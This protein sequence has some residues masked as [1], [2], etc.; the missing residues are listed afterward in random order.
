MFSPTLKLKIFASLCGILFAVG[1]TQL[2]L[3]RFEAGNVYPLYSSL[4]SDPMGTRV[5]FHGYDRLSS[6]T[7]ERNYR[8]WQHIKLNEKTTMMII[9]VSDTRLAEEDSAF[10]K[11][12]E[13]LA[14]SGGRLVLTLTGISKSRFAQDNDL[15]DSGG[16]KEDD[17]AD[18][19]D[20]IEE[21]VEQDAEDDDSSTCDEK[22]YAD[23][24]DALGVRINTI[25]GEPTDD[26][27]ALYADDPDILSL[28]IPWRS[29][30]YFELRDNTWETIYT[31]QD[32]PVVVQRPW[33]KGTVVMAADSYLISNE[34]MRNNRRPGFLTWL[35]V[36]GNDILF[37][38][39]HKGLVKQP[40]VAGLARQYR[41][42]GAFAALLAV[43]ILFVWRQSVIFVPKVQL[44][45]GASIE[46]P[47]VGR[48]TG[49]G[50]VHLARQ[51][52]GTQELLS[53]C[54]ETW[55]AQ[56]S[57]HVPP[58]LMTEI[59]NLVQQSTADSRK[60]VQ[61]QTYKQICQLLKQGKHP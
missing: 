23:G 59:K 18:N 1:L 49:Q 19:A 28:N 54:F 5:L 57:L 60:A 15:W 61:V 43:A 41:L 17:I 42:H 10:A 25:N 11:L 29:Q 45:Q 24:L 14:Q 31:W 40:G 39:Y 37:D 47:T 9:G 50:M 51:H 4:R 6:D 27:A 34:A 48:D 22:G 55:K 36:P 56:A 16:K 2:F 3:L 53:V 58:S 8:P 44:Q 21:F 20:P 13:R 38:E 35:A 32:S 30:L 7:V 26:F 52:I 33:G 12:L 46:Q